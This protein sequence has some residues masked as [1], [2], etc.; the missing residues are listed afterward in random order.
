MLI[1]ILLF[2]QLLQP[3]LSS[4]ENER[5]LPIH[6]RIVNGNEVWP[7][8]KYPFVVAN[9]Y[10]GASLIAPNVLL[11]AAHCAGFVNSVMLGRHNLFDN[12]ENYET[13]HV[14]EEIV[15]PQFSRDTFDYDL[16]ML[17]IDGTSNYK[18][19]AIDDGSNR[20]AGDHLVVMGW[21]STS[22]TGSRSNVLLE[23]E[24]NFIDKD[25]CNRYYG[26]KI[27]DRMFCANRVVDGVT[28]DACSGDSGGPII[29][30]A[31]KLI[32][33]VSW[34]EGCANPDKPG[35]YARVSDQYAWIKQIM[36]QWTIPTPPAG[37][38]YIT[39]DTYNN[40]WP[41]FSGG[42]SRSTPFV[43][44]SSNGLLYHKEKHD[45]SHFHKIQ[46]TFTYKTK[47]MKDGDKL[48]LQYYDSNR[49]RY[50]WLKQ[51]RYSI[52]SLNNH[53]YTPTVIVHKNEKVPFTTDF[54]LRFKGGANEKNGVFLIDEIRVLGQ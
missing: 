49:R 22:F 31:G 30:Q 43:R 18:P 54:K 12:T 21:G 25:L 7:P 15:H 4:D 39:Y 29:D 14:V 8:G 40:G 46:I 50:K 34:G 36:D 53:E 5:K 47:N 19:V 37:W 27:T 45:I 35:V 6:P 42:H 20:R 26:G 9:R 33:V 51:F 16:M 52:N 3:C 10:C 41:N 48:I 24:V 23:A 2:W 28:S 17:R 11:S 1:R 38:S 13:F 44:L 32:G